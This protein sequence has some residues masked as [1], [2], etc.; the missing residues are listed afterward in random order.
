MQ[1]E[2]ERDYQNTLTE[3]AFQHIQI[4]LP[5]RS[6][7]A[8]GTTV[9]ERTQN[10]N[11][12]CTPKHEK[13]NLGPLLALCSSERDSGTQEVCEAVCQNTS[14]RSWNALLRT[15]PERKSLNAQNASSAEREVC[16]TRVRNVE[17]EFQG[18]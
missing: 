18:H 12:E 4:A 8:R 1:P 3:F 7:N 13:H 5:E 16:R 15:Q 14:E 10:A 2:C 6:R 11:P 17:R 9:P